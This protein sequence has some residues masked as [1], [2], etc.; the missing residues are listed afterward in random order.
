MRFAWNKGLTKTDSRVKKYHEKGVETRLKKGSY[1]ANS[2]TFK[3]GQVRAHYP[4]GR[5]N[6]KL[7]KI[8]KEMFRKGLL[9]ISGEDNP[10]Y[11]TKANIKQL[12][13][14]KLGVRKG[15]KNNLWKGGITPLHQVIRTC[16]RYKKWREAVFKRDD[17]IC[18]DCKSRS[19]KGK[20]IYLEA[21]HKKSFS[22][23]LAE[24]NIKTLKEALSCKELWNLKNGKSLCLDCHHRN[25]AQP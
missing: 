10:M 20:R 17:Y 19:K 25:T 11:G 15:D 21:H 7:S 4:K 2:G 6:P 8:R 1:K 12:E 16:K 14:L 9:N 22:S 24:N 5:K 18:Q 13:A 23:I 3:K